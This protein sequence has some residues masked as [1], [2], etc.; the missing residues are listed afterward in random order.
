MTSNRDLTSYSQMTDV[1][2]E[3]DDSGIVTTILHIDEKEVAI[4]T[5]VPPEEHFERAEH[6]EEAAHE[7]TP[8]LLVV[9]VTIAI[10]AVV[11]ATVGSLESIE[12]AATLSAQN[13][14]NPSY[15]PR[16]LIFRGSGAL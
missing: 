14:A 3:Y 13:A 9:S 5:D 16:A 7:G 1:V 12:T 6:A 15:S 4:M 10:L 8:F 2:S 11:A